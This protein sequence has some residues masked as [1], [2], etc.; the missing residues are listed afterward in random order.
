MDEGFV[1]KSDDPSGRQAQG[2]AWAGLFVARQRRA[3]I[4]INCNV[5]LT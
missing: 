4:C 5:K 3:I 2:I 1:S